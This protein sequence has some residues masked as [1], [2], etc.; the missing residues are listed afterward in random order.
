MQS[1]QY[2]IVIQINTR[3]QAEKKEHLETKHKKTITNSKNQ[4]LKWETEI[5]LKNKTKNH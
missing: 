2:N 3:E 1:K 5:H 4:K